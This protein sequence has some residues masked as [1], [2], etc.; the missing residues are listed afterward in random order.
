MEIRS[1]KKVFIIYV[2]LFGAVH[3]LIGQSVNIPLSHWLYDYFDRM[4][5]RQITTNYSPGMHP[6]SRSDAI[7]IVNEIIINSK[8]NPANFSKLERDLLHRAI[9]ELI[10]DFPKNSQKELHFKKEPHLYKWV[11]DSQ[12]IFIDAVFG[13]SGDF[14]KKNILTGEYGAIIRGHMGWFS[15]YSD[16]RIMGEKG[17]GP[18]VNRYD[19]SKGYPYN[20]SPDSSM[21][22]WDTSISYMQIKLKTLHIQYG[23]DNIRW[24]PSRIAGLSMSGIGPGFDFFSLRYKVGNAR[25]HYFHG[26]LQ[27][28][29]VRKWM[30]GHRIELSLGQRGYIGFHETIIYAD[31]NPEMT[32]LNPVMPFLISEHSVGDHDNVGLG[33]DF[34]WNCMP[35]LQL[36]GEIFIDDMVAPWT[37]FDD[38]WSNKKA[39]IIGGHWI[40]PLAIQNSSL[41]I[42]YHRIDPF[43]YTHRISENIYEHYNIGIGSSLQPNSDLFDANMEYYL[44]YKIKVGLRGFFSRHANGDRREAHRPDQGDKSN[45]MKD[46]VEKHAG[47]LFYLHLEPF[48]DLFLK[49][50]VGYLSNDSDADVSGERQSMTLNMSFFWNW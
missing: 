43:V 45:F 23:R 10:D 31:R 14:Y 13:G 24:G 25:L 42:E 21:A 28:A 40:D 36:F 20:G 2:I 48:R 17:N 35:G 5:V 29:I 16:N 38:K 49:G 22:T 27:H 15:F 34:C 19:V 50:S 37:I 3:S 4:A 9:A 6:I 33:L 46:N 7:Q 8:D 47:L 11:N 1:S 32:Y 26:D 39:I 30:A 12:N 41:R 44:N 18:Y